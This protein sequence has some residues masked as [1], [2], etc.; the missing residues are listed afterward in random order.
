MAAIIHFEEFAEARR[1]HAQRV[2]AEQGV[3]IIERNLRLALAQFDEA[4]VA[5]RPLYATRV[6]QLGALLEYAVT[7]A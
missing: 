2:C 3:Q 7:V 4:P 6:R 5:E 1:R